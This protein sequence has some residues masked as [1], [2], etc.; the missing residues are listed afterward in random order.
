[1]FVSFLN[2]ALTK[3]PM[4]LKQRWETLENWE[5]IELNSATKTHMIFN[6]TISEEEYDVDLYYDTNK[7]GGNQTYK[8]IRR[9]TAYIGRFSTVGAMCCGKDNCE[10]CCNHLSKLNI[11]FA[12]AQM[13]LNV[14]P[15]I[16]PCLVGTCKH[17][18]S[19]MISPNNTQ[20]CWISKERVHKII[21]SER[22][23]FI[24]LKSRGEQSKQYKTDILTLLMLKIDEEG[25]MYRKN[26]ESAQ[27]EENPVVEPEAVKPERKMSIE[28]ELKDLR[29]DK[30][31]SFDFQSEITGRMHA[32]R[33]EESKQNMKANNLNANEEPEKEVNKESQAKPVLMNED[34][35]KTKKDLERDL[36]EEIISRLIVEKPKN[37]KARKNIRKAGRSQHHEDSNDDVEVEIIE[38]SQKSMTNTTLLVVIVLG[39]IILFLLVGLF[40]SRTL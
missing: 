1:M 33:K 38:T 20:L 22:K 15:R 12:P 3:L 7:R 31:M 5:V 34:E 25:E 32:H 27:P 9:M 24:K 11:P 36:K 40:L 29:T 16:G 17:A 23:F 26:D 21:G 39:S 28:D 35:R 10:T 8:H 37:R 2:L 19:E 30:K 18:L 6:H 4:T 13:A 14:L